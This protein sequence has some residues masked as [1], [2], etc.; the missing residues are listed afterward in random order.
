LD[1]HGQTRIKQMQR[2]QNTDSLKIKLSRQK[3]KESNSR[4]MFQDKRE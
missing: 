3:S 2:H 4:I 1:R